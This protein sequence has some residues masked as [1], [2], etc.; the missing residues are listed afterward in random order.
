VKVHWPLSVIDE[1]G[2]LTGE[3]VPAGPL[4][5]GNL[6][7]ALI[8]S[9]PS[10]DVSPPTSGNAWRRAT[11]LNV[12]PF[13]DVGDRLGG[14]AYLHTVL[15]LYGLVRRISVPLS[16]YRIHSANAQRRSFNARVKRDLRR[17]ER[18]AT[19]L[20]MHL[21]RLAI[22][23]DPDRWTA[24][25]SSYAWLKAI[26]QAAAEIE[27][28]VP[29]GERYVLVDDQQ[30]ADPWLAGSLTPGR[31]AVPFLE[32]NGAYWGRPASGTQAV[33]E[34]SRMHREGINFVVFAAPAFWWLT[35]YPELCAH[36]DRHGELRSRSA[37]TVIYEL[38][39]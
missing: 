11:L 37:S 4:S 20:A 3:L 30:W 21:K 22:E 7:D 2:D 39:K 1:H 31:E 19:T 17:F 14:D 26:D 29:A 35:H 27:A 28:A 18:R 34:V 32:K 5:D 15:P 6:L 8:E 36:L 10:A 38:R 25:G 24:P 12:Y 33:M 23:H 16:R 13:S 9:G